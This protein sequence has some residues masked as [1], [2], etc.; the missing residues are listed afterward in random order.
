[1][2]GDLTFDVIGA[3]GPRCF[4]AALDRTTIAHAYLFTGPSGTGKKTFARR[5]AQA[6][7]CRAPGAGTAGYDGTCDSC[8]LFSAGE[9]TRN[10]D[11][12]EHTGVMKIG[13]PDRPLGFYEGD[14]LTSRDLVRNL[15][16][17]SYLGGMRVLLLGDV[18]FATPESANALLKILEEP[19][20][21]LVMLMTTSAPDRL[22]ETIRSRAIEV[23]F[24]SL[25]PAEIR[26][27]LIRRGFDEERAA[28][29]ATIGGGSATR[30]MAALDEEE[31]S[32]RSQVAAWFFSAAA[33]GDA[34]DQSWATRETLA[35][36]LE[37]VKTLARD[38]VALGAA[39]EGV[40]LSAPDYGAQLRDLAPMESRAAV[41]MLASLDEAQR[42]ARSNVPPSLVGEMVRMAI[43]RVA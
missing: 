17:Q 25:A 3:Q 42:I 36:G 27:I 11:F 14:D 32:L 1:M 9:D 15:S 23:R 19:P 40:H 10:P 37:I 20:A 29:G 6:M 16:L 39:G 34:P 2:S 26:E 35:E 28:L 8:R 38:W 43:T 22:L 30:A 7:L 33:G 5:L 24:S 41:A 13:D 18:S 31:E 4:F 12:I 21:G